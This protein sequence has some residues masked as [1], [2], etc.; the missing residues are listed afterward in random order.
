MR[1]GVEG[2]GRPRWRS[3]ARSLATV[4]THRP[5]PSV[6]GR[7]RGGCATRCRAGWSGVRARR[8]RAAALACA[9]ELLS[10]AFPGANRQL[11]S[12]R[13]LYLDLLSGPVMRHGS[14]RPAALVLGL[15]SCRKPRGPLHAKAL[16]ALLARCAERLRETNASLP[17]SADGR[18]PLDPHLDALTRCCRGRAADPHRHRA[19]ILRRRPPRRR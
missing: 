2:L 3:C 10:A 4:G 11:T 16:K 8:C 12:A 9:H 5:A 7:A 15:E 17:A 19:S 18:T 6:A 1:Q 13:Q 14:V